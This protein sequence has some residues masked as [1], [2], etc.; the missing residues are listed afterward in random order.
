MTSIQTIIT[1][2]QSGN[3]AE[4]E[5]LSRQWLAQ[6]T[7]D[8]NGLLMLAMS[9][10]FQSKLAEA[11][12]AYRQLTQLHPESSVHWSNYATALSQ[13]G[14]DSDADAAFAIALKLE[15]GNVDTHVNLGL[16]QLRR[17][18][19]MD[20]YRTL[21]SAYDL[22][23]NSARVRIHAARACT[24]SRDPFA[25]ELLKPWRTW[26]PLEETL[27]LELANLLLT[28]G[29]AN[30]AQYLLEDLIS[31]NPGNLEAKLQLASVYERQNQPDKAAV[32]LG[33]IALSHPTLDAG[34]QREIEHQHATLALRKHDLER[35]RQLLEHAGARDANDFAHYFTLADVCD[36]QGDTKAAM[37]ALDVAHARQIDELRL[38][39]PARFSPDSPILPS[40]A[41]SISVEQYAQWPEL[42]APDA[43]QSPV[44]IVG[45]PRSGTTLLEQMLDAHPSLQSMDERPFF[46]ILSDELN[47]ID[48]NVPQ[49]LYRFNQRDCDELRKRYVLLACEKIPR[50]WK[51]QLVDKNPLNMMWL[52]F[53][54]RLFPKAKFILALRHPCDVL[55]SCYMQNFRSSVLIK[56]SASLHEL[57]TAYDTAMRHWLHHV[58][59]FQPDILISRYEDLVAD[60]VSRTQRIAEF[61]QL[62]D[63]TPLMTFDQR[64]REKGYIATPSYTQVIQPVNKKG[65][66]RWHRYREYFEPA[67]PILEPM[68]KHWGY[69]ID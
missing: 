38:A 20:A 23:P 6:T 13:A 46:N 26:L 51:K 48:V 66:N 5:R 55:L 11:T 10:Q 54:H 36:K 19:F 60:P 31:Q 1:L 49:D 29:D 50:D 16:L 61:L 44:F 58:E 17:R 28:S 18:E 8:E 52:P 32:L 42:T 14:N 45:F 12:Q 53:I 25:D 27:H 24:M 7:N 68:L 33:Q 34:A 56:A 69:D 21:L 30:A 43:Q 39:R 37:R 59:V 40:A 3:P 57:A 2:L 4:A 22:D 65:L 41:S 35:S 62:E 67:L 64:A 47:K 63:A 15:P 9:L